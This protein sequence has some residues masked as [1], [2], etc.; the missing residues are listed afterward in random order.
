M[1]QRSG[2]DACTCGGG[3]GVSV[4]AVG[5]VRRCTRPSAPAV[6]RGEGRLRDRGG[7]SDMNLAVS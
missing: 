4:G 3:E 6:L 1:R 2:K 7:V 5:R